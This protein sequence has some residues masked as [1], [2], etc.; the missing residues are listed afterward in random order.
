MAQLQTPDSAPK[1]RDPFADRKLRMPEEDLVKITEFAGK[2]LIVTPTDSG[3][4]VTVH[5]PS[6]YIDADVVVFDDD[7]DAEEHRDVRVFQKVLR[8]QLKRLRSGESMVA[9]LGTKPST[10][11][12]RNDAWI[13]NAPTADQ[14]QVAEK[15]MEAQAGE[16][17][18]AA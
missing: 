11:A 5:G 9:V 1:G 18:D 15:W 12:G 17:G 2:L 6:E 13:F 3:D 16:E 7:G 14:Y 4:M 8:G 10:Q